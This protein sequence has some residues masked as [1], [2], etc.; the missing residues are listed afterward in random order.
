MDLALPRF[1]GLAD[2]PRQVH[3]PWSVASDSPASP[4]PTQLNPSWEEKSRCSMDQMSVSS[5]YLNLDA[6]S[7]SSEKESRDKAKL[8]DLSVTLLCSSSEEAGTHVNSEEAC[9]D[10]DFPAVFGARDI[11]QVVRRRASPPGGQIIGAAQNDRQHGPPAPM[12]DPVTTK[13]NPGKVSR[14][15]STSPLTLDLTVK[16]TSGVKV[17]PPRA[18]T[19]VIVPLATVDN[20]EIAAGTSTP[21]VSTPAPV[22]ERPEVQAK[23]FPTLRLVESPR[24]TSIVRMVVPVSLA[25]AAMGS[26]G[27]L[28]A[29]LFAQPCTVGALTGCSGRGQFVRCV[30]A[31]TRTVLSASSGG[32]LLPTTLDDFDDS[33]LGDPITYARCEH[34]PGSASPLSLPVYAWPPGSAFLLDSTTR[35]TVLAPVSSAL[36]AE[37]PSTSTP[38]LATGGGGG[39]LLETGLPG[40]FV[41]IL[42][43]WRLPFYRRKPG[44]WIAATPPSI[45]G[46]GGSSGVGPTA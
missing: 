39:R 35:Q 16:C 25:H 8:S 28:V 29:A 15:V 37:G 46:A 6:M 38:P 23:G 43:V 19:K 40:L 30:T 5:T 22:E 7:S 41:P 14:T 11:R 4:A 2:G 33:V 31:F 45:S 26:S 18:S 42:R 34:F 9:S 3:P 13:C 27:G 20:T 1:A 10:D 36:P 44:I 21:F 32:V 12:V 24:V 17:P